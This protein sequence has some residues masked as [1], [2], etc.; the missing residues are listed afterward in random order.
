MSPI[1]WDANDC[2]TGLNIQDIT[3]HPVCL[4]F[5]NYVIQHVCQIDLAVVKGAS[6]N[7]KAYYERGEKAAS[8]ITMMFLRHYYHYYRAITFWRCYKRS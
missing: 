7:I 4:H 3:R 5:Y 8:S 1:F 2:A 6:H